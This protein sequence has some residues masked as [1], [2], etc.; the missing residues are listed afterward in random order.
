MFSSNGAKFRTLYYKEFL[1]R[2]CS[3]QK[4]CSFYI[5]IPPLYTMA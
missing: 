3:I 2:R 5:L 4:N 1:D